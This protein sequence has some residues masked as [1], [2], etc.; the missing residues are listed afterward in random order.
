MPKGIIKFALNDVKI[1]KQQICV[2]SKNFD[3]DNNDILE[4]IKILLDYIISQK[5]KKK[6]VKMFL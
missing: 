3:I 2:P 1:T 5:R 4:N 6:C